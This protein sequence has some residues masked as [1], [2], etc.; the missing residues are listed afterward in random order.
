MQKPL[1]LLGLVWAQAYYIQVRPEATALRAQLLQAAQEPAPFARSAPIWQGLRNVESLL[2]NA[3]IP[4]LEGWFGL[5][6]EG[7]DSMALLEA[8]RQLPGVRLAE[9]AA[10]RRLCSDPAPLPGWHHFAIGTPTAWT[11]TQGSPSVVIGL[12]D[13]GTE[14]QLPAFHR[15]LWINSAEDL[16]GNGTL[17][18][19][20]LN[21][22]DEDGNGFVDDVIG[23][24]FTDQPFQLSYWG[25]FR[26]G[27]VARR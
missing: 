26:V 4:E 6:F 11:Y 19:A 7:R 14:W 17:D 3:P 24:D 12:L 18:P 16:N 10:C 22:I 20:D 21:D 23:Y 15:Q 8:L 27:P 25:F 9:P 5:H 13:S 1:L 2:P